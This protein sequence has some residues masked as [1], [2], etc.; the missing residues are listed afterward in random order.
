MT[1]K[2]GA[3]VTLARTLE[4]RVLDARHRRRARRWSVATVRD[5]EA[6]RILARN[7]KAF[8]DT[9]RAGRSKLRKADEVRAVHLTNCA[10]R[11]AQFAAELT[12]KIKL[13]G[14]FRAPGP[15][16]SRR[17]LR[18]PVGQPVRVRRAPRAHGRRPIRAVRRRASAA[19][20][21]DS[22]PLPPRNLNSSTAGG[23]S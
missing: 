2:P 5:P 7:S 14:R 19:R 23:R 6:E 18:R 12:Q 4:R 10:E 13:P 21:S 9:L 3:I 1:I 15:G 8:G 11:V 17:A 22:D 20:T 16:Q